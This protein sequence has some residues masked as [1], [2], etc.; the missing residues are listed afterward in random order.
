MCSIFGTT[1]YSEVTNY[2]LFLDVQKIG[3]LRTYRDMT[4]WLKYILGIE[5][6]N[7]PVWDI[8]NED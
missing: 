5:F 1:W 8:K 6:Y 7:L 2:F 4:E 3:G